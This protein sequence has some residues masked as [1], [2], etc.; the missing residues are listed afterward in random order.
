MQQ[1][2]AV[3]MLGS[4]VFH[5]SDLTLQDLNLVAILLRTSKRFAAFALALYF[6]LHH[7]SSPKSGLLKDSIFPALVFRI[8]FTSAQQIAR[9]YLKRFPVRLSYSRRHT[10]LRS[11]L[12][13]V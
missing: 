9:A 3:R 1:L 11:Q 4:T 12:A 5:S 13:F 10:L 2:R 6:A 8:S 7:P